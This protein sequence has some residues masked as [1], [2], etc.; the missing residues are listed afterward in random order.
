M[1]PQRG[2]KLAAKAT[3]ILMTPFG[4]SGSSCGVRSGAL[5]S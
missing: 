3:R 2:K 1:K 5:C 4:L